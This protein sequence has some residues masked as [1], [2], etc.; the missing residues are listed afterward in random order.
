MDEKLDAFEDWQCLTLTFAVKA[1]DPV[2]G[3]EALQN[4][5]W[6]ELETL[7]SRAQGNRSAKATLGPSGVALMTAATLRRAIEII[8]A[9]VT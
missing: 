4:R 2:A 1:A 7:W 6:H 3:G 5:V 8:D 9:A